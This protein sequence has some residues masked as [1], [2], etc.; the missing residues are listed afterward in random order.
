MGTGGNNK[1]TKI[2]QNVA[3]QINRAF[4]CEDT[5]FGVPDG[6]TPQFL[7]NTQVA[8]VYLLYYDKDNDVEIEIRVKPRVPLKK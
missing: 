6:C 1:F 2:Y 7:Q 4:K 3:D 5:E 8:G